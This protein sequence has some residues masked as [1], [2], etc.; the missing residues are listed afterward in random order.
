MCV[1]ILHNDVHECN[2]VK[3]QRTSMK[4][5]I[6]GL[7]RFNATKKHSVVHEMKMGNSTVYEYD[8]G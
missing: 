8:H 3:L 6:Q 5:Q 4:M 7:M 2:H 1:N